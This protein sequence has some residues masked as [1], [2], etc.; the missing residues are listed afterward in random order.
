M[1]Y[2]N[3]CKL[4]ELEGKFNESQLKKAYY[5][6]AIKYH[7]DKNSK[8]EEKFKEIGSAYEY[9]QKHKKLKVEIANFSYIEL[10][11]KF[12]NMDFEKLLTYKNMDKIFEKTGEISLKVFEKLKKSLAIE[13]YKIILKYK[14]VLSIKNETIKIMKEIIHKKMEKDNLIILNPSIDDLM[15]NKVY[16]LNYDKQIFHCPL[17]QRE[18]CFDISGNDLIIKCMVEV[19]DHI[20]IDNTNNIIVQYKNK[21]QQIFDEGKITFNIG[22][23][24]FVIPSKYLRVSK[25]QT[26]IFKGEG[27]ISLN[28]KNIYD[29]TKKMDIVVEIFLT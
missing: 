25:Y 5:K 28:E 16:K 17:W 24:E 13:I 29:I 2:K 22:K 15:E 10:V 9:L 27:I 23:R 8:T 3:A 7:P 12:F 26:Y 20:T 6:K 1:D 19:P 4:L 14:K 18:I 21:I 11:N